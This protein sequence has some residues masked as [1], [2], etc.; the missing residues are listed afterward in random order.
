MPL[1]LI[2]D[3]HI[4]KAITRGLASRN[5]NVLTAQDAGGALLSDPDLLD[6]AARLNRIMFSYDDDMLKEAHFRM[7]NGI[8]FKGVIYVHAKKYSF[9]ETIRA[10]TALSDKTEEG[11]MDNRIVFLSQR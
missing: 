1:R 9:G 11:A 7:K 6:L 3:V 10:M 5:V 8:P 2:M 4:P